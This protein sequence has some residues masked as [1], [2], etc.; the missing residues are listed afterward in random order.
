MRF[1][2]IMSMALLFA[3]CGDNFDRD[4]ML[5]GPRGT[6]DDAADDALVTE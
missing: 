5:N 3:G 6:P 1:L 4:E 2:T